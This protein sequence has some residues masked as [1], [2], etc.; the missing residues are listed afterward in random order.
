M[1][2]G[3]T[4][5]R[6]EDRLAVLRAEQQACTDP[7]RHAELGESIAYYQGE[8]NDIEASIRE[9]ERALDAGLSRLESL[10]P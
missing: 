4:L 5:Q 8:V 7:D 2:T 1:N 10:H 6:I 9:D 3:H